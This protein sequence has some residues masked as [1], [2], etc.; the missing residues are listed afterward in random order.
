VY[1]TKPR[2]IDELKRA[3]RE[4]ITATPDNM[5]RKALN[6]LRDSLEQCRRDGTHLRD[7]FFRK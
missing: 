5:V 6:T 3:I 1:L 2:D 4:E 7:V